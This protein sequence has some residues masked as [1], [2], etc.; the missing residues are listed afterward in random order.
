ML[1][2]DLGPDD[3]L[4]GVIRVETNDREVI[5][6]HFR[7]PLPT[8]IHLQLA[9]DKELSRCLDSGTLEPTP[10]SYKWVSRGKFL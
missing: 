7:T 6:T 2:D 5:P 10:H 4:K 1:K 3:T 8:P 9:A